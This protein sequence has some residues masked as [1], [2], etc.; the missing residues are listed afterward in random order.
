MAAVEGLL[1]S[2]AAA[3]GE[4]FAADGAPL[5]SEDACEEEEILADDGQSAKADPFQAV[6][7][8]LEVLM[9]DEGL[10]AQ[11]DAFTKEH[12]GQFEPGD[13]NKL[14]YTTLFNQYTQMV[15]AYIEQQLGASV[16]SFDMAGFCATL[17]E[18]AKSDESLLDHPALE[19]LFAYSDFEAFKALMLLAGVFGLKVDFD[20]LTPAA[21]PLAAWL[22]VLNHLRFAGLVTGVFGFPLVPT[23]KGQSEVRRD[24]CR[25][26]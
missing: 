18:R 7:G 11:V 23:P 8:E 10:N 21:A 22:L 9:M 1:D 12:C 25:A 3:D 6:L 13:E 26:W 14:E 16:A 24:G 2:S 4:T 20:D 17:S 15:E 19:M 5:L